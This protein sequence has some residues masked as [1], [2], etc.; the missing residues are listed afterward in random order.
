MQ[1]PATPTDEMARLQS[2]WAHAV[3]DTAP[4][5]RFDRFT[6][7]AQRVF[8]VPIA[9]VSLVDSD[10]Q[11]FKS[12][13]GLDATETP[14]DISFCGHVVA[15]D[16]VL[17]VQDTADDQRF[18]DNPLVTGG[19]EIRF[20]A[21]HPVRSEDGH[22][23]GTFCIIDRKPRMLSPDDR[24]LLADMAHMVQRELAA[25]RLA[26]TDTLTGLS[27]RRG[28]E[29]VATY[30]LAVAA[31]VDVPATLLYF[32]LD[33]L[34]AINDVHGH[35]AGDEAIDAFAHALVSTFR[36]ADVIARL[37]GDEFAVLCADADEA[38]VAVPLARLRS[39]IE[40][41]VGG[42]E[43]PHAIEFSVGV[44]GFDPARHGGLDGL[45]SAADAAMYARKRERKAQ[46]V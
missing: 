22:A 20:Y 40:A 19:P 24:T 35:A 26:A 5:E 6:R 27:N 34:K 42:S 45:L 30:A 32:D 39:N 4:E 13:A 17:V 14:R 25:L 8:D 37:G 36:S 33:G 11:W 18:A 46:R 10:R 29:A 23:L 28:F 38:D 12:R 3:L 43:R 44:V 31:R 41:A 15:D 21:G 7:L 16:E 1:T 2:L 9:L